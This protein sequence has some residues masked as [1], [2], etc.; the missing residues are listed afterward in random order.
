[1]IYRGLGESV[2]PVSRAPS[3]NAWRASDREQRRP[4]APET[5]RIRSRA[6]YL[7]VGGYAALLVLVG[8]WPV[9]YALDLALTSVGG[10]F[11]GLAN[12]TDTFQGDRL[13]TAFVHVAEFMAVWLTGL[14][15]IVV[16]LCLLI[17]TF[18]PRVGASFRFVFYLPAAFAGSASVLLWLFMLDPSTSPWSPLLHATGHRTLGDSLHGAALPFVFALIAFWT[19]AGVWIIVIHGA[20]ADIPQ[21]VLEAAALDGASAVQTALHVKLPLIR[22]WIV[23]MAV[24]S[25]AAGTQLFT[26]PQLV[27]E[28]SHKMVDPTWSPNTLA[29]FLAF[30]YDN[31]NGAAAISVELLVLAVACAS[32]LVFRTGFFAAD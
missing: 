15:A 21:D 18:S 7:F 27:S 10:S 24:V 23:Y 19:G 1:M 3:L 12:V 9:G 31:F 14:I 16:A 30:Q 26:E 22:K 13:L 5:G 28:A 25:F 11:S 2:S 4:A 32:L 8:L 29:T 6:G 17:H 20:L